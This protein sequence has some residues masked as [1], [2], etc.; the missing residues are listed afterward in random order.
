M[1]VLLNKENLLELENHLHD[2]QMKY[3][4]ET[5]VYNS[6]NTIKPVS[7]QESAKN[8]LHFLEQLAKSKGFE[9]IIKNNAMLFGK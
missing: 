4:K 2:I 8:C 3:L 1:K 7:I 6:I 9:F 5:I